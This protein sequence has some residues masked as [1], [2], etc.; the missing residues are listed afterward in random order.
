MKPRLLQLVVGCTIGLLWSWAVLACPTPATAAPQLQSAGPKL[1]I[2]DSLPSGPASTVRVPIQLDPAGQRVSGI[3]FPLNY[4]ESCLA[5]D[6][7]DGN[8][9]GHPDSIQFGAPG[10]FTKSVSVRP[11]DP[12]T[13]LIFVIADYS[14]PISTFAAGTLM[15]ITFTTHCPRPRARASTPR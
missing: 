5:F 7:S 9:D 3:A 8:D 6:A 13:E 11:N 10:A 2:P 4:D 1:T 12:D 14:Q 15:T